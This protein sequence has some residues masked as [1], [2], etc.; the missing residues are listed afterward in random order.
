M[1]GCK[2]CRI[3]C[4]GVCG[5]IG[6]SIVWITISIPTIAKIIDIMITDFF[7]TSLRQY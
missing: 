7:I 6:T 5:I 1:L 3:F 2:Q 4:C